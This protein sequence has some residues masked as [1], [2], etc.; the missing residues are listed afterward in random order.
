MNQIIRLDSKLCISYLSIHCSE[1]ISE[2]HFDVHSPKIS[3][4]I[5]FITKGCVEFVTSTTRISAQEGDLIYIPEGVRYVSH[6]HGTPKI[7]FYS[8][9]FRPLETA[10][11]LW[12]K[13]PISKISPADPDGVREKIECMVAFSQA[14][15][16]VQAKAYALYYQ[17]AALI[18]EAFPEQDIRR[19]PEALDNALSYANEHFT[20]VQSVKELARVC[21]LSESRLFHLFREYLH[22][23][24][25][26]Y[27]NNLKIQ[28]AVEMLKKSDKPISQIAA[29]LNF[30]SDFY[31][32]KVFRQVTGVLPSQFRKPINR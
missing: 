26:A 4:S 12:R 31:F 25:T 22:T 7:C 9:H 10:V 30:H 32:R 24:P 5:G 20:Q 23:T 21:F 16:E 27:L 1:Y 15:L 19:L 18:L 14:E 28:A 2:H 11:P 17:L 29:S 13:I 8:I 3:N 6:W